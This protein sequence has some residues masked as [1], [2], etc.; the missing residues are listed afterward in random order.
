MCS[1]LLSMDQC[2][3]AC[4]IKYNEYIQKAQMLFS[5]DS[6]Y[7]TLFE[8]FKA[9]KYSFDNLLCSFIALVC[10]SLI[11]LRFANNN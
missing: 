10:F 5:N 3:M 2:M 4:Y 8:R 6:K 9:T 7:K 1:K 11:I